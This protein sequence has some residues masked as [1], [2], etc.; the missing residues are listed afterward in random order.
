MRLLRAASGC[1]GFARRSQVDHVRAGLPQHRHAERAVGA[2]PGP[3]GCRVK[4]TIVE[5]MPRPGRRAGRRRGRP[6]PAGRAARW[7]RRRSVAAGRPLMLALLT[8]IG[9]VRR[10]MSRASSWSGTRSA[11]VPRSRP[12]PS[13]GWAG[14]CRSR[15]AGRASAGRP[16]PW[17]PVGT[18]TASARIRLAVGDQH[19]RRH[20]AAAV[21]RVQQPLDRLGA[22]RVGADPVHG[23]GGQHDALAAL[24]RAA[25]RLGCAVEQLGDRRR[26]SRSAGSPIGTSAVSLT[27]PI[28]PAISYGRL[29]PDSSGCDLRSS[30]RTLGPAAPAGERSHSPC[31]RETLADGVRATRPVGRGPTYG[32]D[33]ARAAG[34]VGVVADLPVKRSARR[35]HR[36]RR[37]P[38]HV[39]VLEAESARPSQ[40]PRRHPVPRP[41]SRPGRRRRRTGPTA[42]SW[43]RASGATDS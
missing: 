35:H 11:M 24:D 13:A 25:G 42:G 3:I 28:V 16:G 2:A 4:S 40:Q 18:S 22:E 38:L 19:R 21:L 23:V 10:R 27:R 15:S 31:R 34:Q 12:G 5:G 36:G 7:R 20:V 26:C 1:R 29:S 30:S 14:P 32:R 6:P 39:G 43:S 33:E 9:P 8:A 17:P 41:G 37:L